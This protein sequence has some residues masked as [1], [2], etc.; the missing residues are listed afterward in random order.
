MKRTVLLVVLGLL[1]LILFARRVFGQSI[2]DVESR[3]E[4]GITCT[5]QEG[6]KVI[7]DKI[8]L[9][10]MKDVT[11]QFG[12]VLK[13]NNKYLKGTKLISRAKDKIIYDNSILTWG[14]EGK[15][16]CYDYKQLEKAR[17]DLE[18]PFY[19]CLLVYN[20]PRKKRI[21]LKEIKFS[22]SDVMIADTVDDYAT[23][24]HTDTTVDTSTNAD[25]Q[26]YGLGSYQTRERHV[27]RNYEWYVDQ[28]TTGSHNFENCGPSV[29][30]MAVKWQ[31]PSF[32]KTGEDARNTY[33]AGGG[34]W[35][36]SDVMHYL[37]DNG[38]PYW[39]IEAMGD[40]G[41]FT[42][43]IDSGSVII[44]CIDISQLTYND[45]P[46]QRVDGFFTGTGH[47]VIIKGYRVVDNV[48]YYEMYDPNS[49]GKKYADGTLRGKDR[50]YKHS[51]I[52]RAMEEWWNY[53]IVVTQ[54]ATRAKRGV[55]TSSIPDKSGA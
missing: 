1:T 2:G 28:Y 9:D 23:D 55:D 33:R 25:I 52:K 47:F 14:K 46:R 3:I 51:E 8:Q 45:N 50:Y 20:A 16:F 22:L 26:A 18:K 44:L 49:W 7:F 11:V 54:Y 12:C 40:T 37:N 48:L 39:A 17:I 24:T 10:R 35:Y 34:W 21:G 6:I 29:A 13:Q 42:G 5:G 41:D 36:T 19:A 38:V 15:W 30:T 27:E 31:K 43:F 53:A 32:S 4:T